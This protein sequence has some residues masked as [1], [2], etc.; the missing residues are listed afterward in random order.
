MAAYIRFR[1]LNYIGFSSKSPENY[2]NVSFFYLCRSC[3]FLNYRKYAPKKSKTH[4][5]AKIITKLIIF[6]NGL[7]RTFGYDIIQVLKNNPSALNRVRVFLCPAAGRSVHS[8][9]F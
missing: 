2:V 9:V 1:R 8:G 7:K 5:I 4:V 3:I 6:Q